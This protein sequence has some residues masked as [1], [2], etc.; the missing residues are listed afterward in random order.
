MCV[1]RERFISAL[2]VLGVS[3]ADFERYLCGEYNPGHNAFT[4][5]ELLRR[6]YLASDVI[7]LGMLWDHTDEGF[8]FWD[9]IWERIDSI[10]ELIPDRGTANGLPT[11][12]IPRPKGRKYL[13]A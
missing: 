2:K 4:L 1:N 13:C 12:K 6:K 10:Y 5:D 8:S 11:G 7:Q 9:R 3:L